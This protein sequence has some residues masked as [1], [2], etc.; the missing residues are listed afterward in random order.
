MCGWKIRA[1]EKLNPTKW[2]ALNTL[3]VK[4]WPIQALKTNHR[5]IIIYKYVTN[6]EIYALKIIYT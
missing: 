4:W 1:R 6:S 2:R 5:K 3:E